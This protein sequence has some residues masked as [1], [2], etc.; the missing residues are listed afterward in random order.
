MS[1]LDKEQTF[2]ANIDKIV[3][4]EISAHLKGSLDELLK[5]PS[6]ADKV[7]VYRKARGKLQNAVEGQFLNEDETL[8]I[9]GF[10]QDMSDISSKESDE[11]DRVGTENKIKRF[12]RGAVLYGALLFL[13]Y[14]IVASFIPEE[15]VKFNPLES[16]TYETVELEDA[17]EE[18][19]DF[20]S[21]SFEDVREFFNNFPNPNI[22]N[23]QLFEPKGWTLE[24][25]SVIDY[26]VAVIAATTFTKIIKGQTDTVV[27][28]VEEYDENG[29]LLAPKTI[30][31]QVPSKDIL[32]HYSFF[33]EENRFPQ[34]D[35]T[36][37]GSFSYYPFA[38]DKYNMIM[39]N[40]DKI[41]NVL[42]GRLTPQD[43]AAYVSGN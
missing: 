41:Y 37:V 13:G 34:F 22:K 2:Y 24:G 15:V 1:N 25:A 30:E 10:A 32:V 17:M 4:G 23:V 14:K 28:E 16:F 42:V 33:S 31:T 18:R 3:N 27:E 38:S 19:I 43:M 35:P 29:E 26:D 21:N 5:D 6:Y 40:K 12:I 39:W 7:E 8:K 9:R 36:V 11:I 20:K